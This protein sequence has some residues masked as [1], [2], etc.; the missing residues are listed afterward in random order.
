MLLLQQNWVCGSTRYCSVNSLLKASLL[1]IFFAADL[2]AEVRMWTDVSGRK[3][4]AELIATDGTNATLLLPT[5][6]EVPYPITKLSAEDQQY[7]KSMG[8]R[9]AASAALGLRRLPPPEKR[10]WPVAVQ[11]PQSAVDVTLVSANEV[12]DTYLYQN[13]AFQFKSQANLLPGLMYSVAETFEA[14]RRLMQE[15]PWGITCRPPAGMKFYVAELYKNRASYIAAGGPPNSGGVYSTRDRIF[16]IP[17]ESLGLEQRGKSFTRADDYSTGTLVHEITH[18]VMHDYINHL[19]TWVVEGTAE[20]AQ[21]LPYKSGTFRVVAGAS[22]FKEYL[23]RF[24][25]MDIPPRVPA[26]AT[27]MLMPRSEWDRQTNLGAAYMQSCILVYYF[28]HLDGDGRGLN[29]M[30]FMDAT[31]E[32]MIKWQK[33]EQEF[34][35]YRKEMDEFLKKPGVER[36]EGGMIRYPRDMKAPD[37]P[38]APDG[39][40]MTDATALQNVKVLLAERDLADVQLEMETKLQPIFKSLK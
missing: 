6:K 17:F 16:K 11:T 27:F 36:L 35:H 2:A 1:L 20:Y 7:I 8:S 13:Q 18:Q 40:E 26:L 4:E 37:A 34:H 10:V 38:E 31:R 3:V 24:R 9:L 32:Q 25:A 28:N 39:K 12:N 14:T 30:R 22:G 19:P 5:G 33:Y 15:L 21:M 29:F 23:A